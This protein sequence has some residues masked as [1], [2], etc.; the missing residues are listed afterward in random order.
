MP[1]G[2]VEMRDRC[3]MLE[4]EGATT[5]SEREMIEQIEGLNKICGREECGIKNPLL[6]F[7]C[8]GDE[9]NDDMYDEHPAPMSQYE[10]D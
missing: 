1:K 6:C 4:R 3:K 10:R 2:E 9:A 5:R 7:G 8:L